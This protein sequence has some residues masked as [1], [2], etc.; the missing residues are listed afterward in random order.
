MQPG[1]QHHCRRAR[2]ARSAHG[3]FWDAPGLHHA[4]AVHR[5]PE[6]VCPRLALILLTRPAGGMLGDAW[7]IRRPFELACCSFLVA[8]LYVFVALPYMAPETLSDGKRPKVRGIA[9]FFAPLRVMVPQSLVL[10]SGK[11]KKHHGVL[12]LCAGVFLGVVGSGAPQKKHLVLTVPS[13]PRATRPSSS[14]CT[15]RPNSSSASLITD[16]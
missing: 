13:W 7:G 12:F 10:P 8:T 4:G 2:S 6:Y 14:K 5:V 11:I 16:G 9:G 15:P 1:R 3:D